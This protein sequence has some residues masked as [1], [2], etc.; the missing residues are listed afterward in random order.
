[1]LTGFF[2]NGRILSPLCALLTS[3]K[4][5][6]NP[7][8]A[9]LARVARMLKTPHGRRRSDGRVN[10]MGPIVMFSH[11]STSPVQRSRKYRRGHFSLNPA[12][13]W[14]VFKFIAISKRGLGFLIVIAKLREAAVTS[15]S[16]WHR[17]ENNG[18]YRSDGVLASWYVA[19]CHSKTKFV[20]EKAQC[21]QLSAAVFS[22]H[23]YRL[24]L[25]PRPI[26]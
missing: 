22:L 13:Y 1:M 7:N 20:S 8:E 9:E 12:V 19:V 15:S 18:G 4:Y 23:L 14:F 11:P 6:N 26:S 3:S 17:H 24:S 10:I 25:K 16:R 2:T 21:N 5:S